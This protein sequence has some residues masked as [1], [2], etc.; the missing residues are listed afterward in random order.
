MV[1]NAAIQREYGDGK[2]CRGVTVLNRR[3]RDSLTKKMAFGQRSAG[4]EGAAGRKCS[5]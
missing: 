1:I 2:E 3:I 5:R 4:G